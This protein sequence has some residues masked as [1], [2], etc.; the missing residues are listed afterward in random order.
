MMVNQLPFA[1][2]FARQCHR[3]ESFRK[4]RL[5]VCLLGF[6]FLATVGKAQVLNV[7]SKRFQKDSIG[8]MGTTAF[9]MVAVKNITS[10]LQFGNSTQLQYRTA[11]T[12]YLFL[13]EINYLRSATIASL[14][15]GYTHLRAGRNI[16]PYL[17]WES[18]AQGQYNKPLRLDIRLSAG[19][20]IRVRMIKKERIRMY[21]ACIPMFEFERETANPNP[22]RELRAS[23]YLTLTW[24]IQEG[25]ELES[26][27]YYQ[28][29]L[30]R[31]D[32]FRIAGEASLRFRLRKWLSFA[33]S[34]QYLLDTQQPKDVPSWTY[35]LENRMEIVF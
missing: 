31:A 25:T 15:T 20:G 17:T 30:F 8:W 11:S 27:T 24:I 33:C 23:N 26:T 7:E 14:N 34:Y 2:G 22:I 35:R 16:H 29:S 21:G 32:D 19:S 6:L 10:V 28:P 18:F 13:N 12:R 9:R 1:L 3:L 4:V 5:V